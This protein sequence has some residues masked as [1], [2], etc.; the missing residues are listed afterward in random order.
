MS[1]HFLGCGESAVI[2][3]LG[4]KVHV[5][6]VYRHDESSA[7]YGFFLVCLCIRLAAT[8][9]FVIRLWD[10][11]CSCVLTANSKRYTLHFQLKQPC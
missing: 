9:I 1:E 2:S 8:V 7:V 4:V 5:A 10:T 11:T 3:A 6:T